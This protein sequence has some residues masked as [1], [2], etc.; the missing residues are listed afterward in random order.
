MQIP[1]IISSVQSSFQSSVFSKMTSTP[2]IC[3]IHG[4]PC[5]KRIR[6][7]S[8]RLGESPT[9]TPNNSLRLPPTLGPTNEYENLEP[10][11]ERSLI[12]VAHESNLTAPSRRPREFASLT[13]ENGG[14]QLPKSSSKA[15]CDGVY[16]NITMGQT[17]GQVHRQKNSN[18]VKGGKRSSVDVSD[19]YIGVLN[20]HEASSL[21]NERGAFRLFHKVPSKHVKFRHLTE[22]LPLYVVYCDSKV[23]MLFNP[24]TSY[25]VDT[26]LKDAPTFAN[27]TDLVR[28][29]VT[30]VYLKPNSDG[31]IE[32][33]CFEPPNPMN[34]RSQKDDFTS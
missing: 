30:Y 33:E 4:V 26:K 10:L 23:T 3:C 18:N 19:F 29:Y 8:A 11:D 16:E 24:P 28:Y 2:L 1:V 25:Y 15:S 27:L 6:R 14:T 5:K 13:S 12:P 22:N 34:K 20:R 9:Q 32:T 31:T 7:P 21:C 17:D